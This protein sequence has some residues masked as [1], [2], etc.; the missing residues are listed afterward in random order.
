MY[1]TVDELENL[2]LVIFVRYEL[3]IF[4]RLTLDCLTDICC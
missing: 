1:W 2:A 3:V 4:F